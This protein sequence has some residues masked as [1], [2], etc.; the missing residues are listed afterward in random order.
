MKILLVHNY[1][2]GRSPGGE[3][4]VVN[5]ERDVLLGAG[6]EV[7]MYT[8]SNDEMDETSWS[9]RVRVAGA[10]QGF[11]RTPGDL[12]RLI[13]QHRPDVT[14]VHNIFPLIGDSVF[15]V[16]R[17]LGV[18]SVHTLHSFRP[19]CL[20]TTHYRDGAVCELCRPGEY[21][22]GVRRACYRRSR[23]AS[24]LVAGAQ[25]RS[26]KAH[27]SGR[28]ADR[29]LVLTRF[30][31][32]RLAGEALPANRIQVRPNFV[33][34]PPQLDAQTLSI[35]RPG[36]PYAVFTG[37]IAPEKGLRTLLRA[38]KALPDIPLKVIGDGPE[39]AEV[40][41]EAARLGLPIE[42]LGFQSR[43]HSLSWVSAAALQVVP[44]EWFEGMP[45]VIL[46]AWALG[47][48]V[49]ASRLGGCAEL[50]G[51][52]ERGLGFTAGDAA[53]LSVQVRRLWSDRTVATQIA[54]AGRARYAEC[55]TPQ[56]GLASL[57]EAYRATI[58]S[59]ECSL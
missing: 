30:A 1:Y 23:L 16:C 7:V 36:A 38:W 14:H 25:A 21:T 13:E 41:A 29:Y 5:A 4:V 56:Q 50:I 3:D 39:M 26:V 11:T 44:S 54:S 24:R 46:E 32:D 9:D 19:S 43:E 2:R 34:L 27:R 37:K 55:H 52:D 10:L 47:V 59:V 6:H 51:N 40:R 17:Q 45:L 48:P 42:F 28:G 20:A 53:A 33:A 49:V 15:D 57:L 58:A 31:A 22:E 12:R 18:P 8:R 35:A